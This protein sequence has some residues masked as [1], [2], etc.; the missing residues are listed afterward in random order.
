[1]PGCSD[2]GASA[3][4]D[5]PPSQLQAARDTI[6]VE[7]RKLFLATFI[8]RDFMPVSPP[9]GKPLIAVLYVTATDTVPLPGSI[10]ADAVWIVYDNQVWK[11]WLRDD[12]AAGENKRYRLVKIAREGPNWG[13]GV[14]V[15]VVV[16]V[17]DGSHNAFLLRAPSQWISRTD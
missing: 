17:F 9:D 8:W 6:T 7:G 2:E 14:A 15:D 13:P 16:R 5:L 4:P 12:P 1:M 11:S 3:P 10:S